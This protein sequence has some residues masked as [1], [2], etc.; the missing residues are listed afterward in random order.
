VESNEIYALETLYDSS[1][2]TKQPIPLVQGE[3]AR[4]WD[5]EGRRYIDCIGGHGV[6]NVGHANP[7]VTRAIQEQAARLIVCPDNFPNDR[8]AELLWELLHI[9]PPGL[10]RAFLCNSGTEAVEG[11]LKFARLATGRPGIVA[12]MRGFHGR[13][14]G[15]L[16]ATWNKAY[17]KPFE[18]LVPGFRHV[19]YNNLEAMDKAVD[20]ETAAVILEVVQGEGGV[21]PGDADYLQGVQALCRERGTLF[22]V[23]EVQ[24]GFGRTGRMFACE[25]HGLQPDILCVAKGIAAGVP[26][27]AVLTGSRVEPLPRKVH[28]STFGGN[29]LACAA[30]VATIRY[31]V[32]ERLPERAAEL[33]AYFLG[34]LRALSS[35]LIRDVRGLGLMVGVELKRPA[36]PFLA[37]M[38]QQGVLALQAGSTV[39]RF[40]P[41]LVIERADLRQVVETLDAVLQEGW[42]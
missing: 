1:V 33:G 21:I 40:L 11:A 36:G 15:A 30:A 10:E 23:D 19:P 17:R 34:E 24:T 41:P 20:G 38:A 9:V 27:G 16:S 32:A 37:A 4:L 2:H 26:M 39:V 28:G 8:R 35:P 7:A 6:A 18:P 42:E 29:P 31:L 25:H 3:G 12:A 5:A 14:M 22:V 13:T